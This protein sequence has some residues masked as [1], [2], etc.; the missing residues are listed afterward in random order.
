MTLASRG[1]ASVH[2]IFHRLRFRSSPT[3]D[4]TDMPASRSIPFAPANVALCC[5]RFSPASAKL[6]PLAQCS[7]LSRS[8]HRRRIEERHLEPVDLL[9]GAAGN[10]LK[11]AIH[12]GGRLDH[13]ADLFLALGPESDRRLFLAVEILLHRR[14]LLD[15][16]LDA[17]LEAGAGQITVDHFHLRLLPLP[18]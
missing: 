3:L 10:P 15:D 13:A 18:R 16:G 9:E 4:L 6:T 17:V 5:C 8:R 14:E 1:V 2:D 11:I 7:A 12:A